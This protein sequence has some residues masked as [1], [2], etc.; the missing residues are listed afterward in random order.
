M[1]PGTAGG[2]AVGR[3]GCITANL[4]LERVTITALQRACSAQE[5][6]EASEE[7]CEPSGHLQPVISCVHAARA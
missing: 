4:V 1:C 3:K 5:P 2:P 7:V 6:D